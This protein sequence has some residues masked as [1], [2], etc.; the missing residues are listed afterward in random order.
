MNI[1]T[2]LEDNI[3]QQKEV[4]MSRQEKKEE[5]STGIS[6][7]NFITGT[8]AAMAGALA[9]GALLPGKVEAVPPPKKWDRTHD[10]LIIGTGYAGLAAAIE[11]MMPAA[12]S[13]SSRRRP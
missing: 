13:P 3:D 12:R 10:V 1:V 2:Q 7:R 6:R 11:P 9:A 5:Q 8:G 4:I